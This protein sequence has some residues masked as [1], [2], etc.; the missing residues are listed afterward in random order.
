M[1]KPIKPFNPNSKKKP[2]PVVR[3]GRSDVGKKRE[4]YEFKDKE[5]YCK[6]RAIYHSGGMP[7]KEYDHEIGV[8]L[9]NLIADGD[10]VV[11]ACSKVHT[12]YTTIRRWRIEDANFRAMYTEAIRAKA[13]VQDA[14]QDEVIRGMVNGS[15]DSKVA[16]E[17]CKVYRWRAEK[18][19]PRLYGVNQEQPEDE[20]KAPTDLPPE[21]IMA[22]I[23]KF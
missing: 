2:K 18:Y 1:E 16:A 5:A 14:K 15:I 19:F 7:I 12:A 21:V 9:C 11:D 3:K 6:Q 17:M 23:D 20:R 10:N 22:M 4:H 8:E 13:E